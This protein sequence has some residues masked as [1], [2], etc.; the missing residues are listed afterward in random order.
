MSI[1]KLVLDCLSQTRKGGIESGS[2]SLSEQARPR[3]RHPPGARNRLE[4]RSAPAPSVEGPADG[5]APLSVESGS[6]Q[7]SLVHPM[8]DRTTRRVAALNLALITASCTSLEPD[9]PI[10]TPRSEEEEQEQEVGEEEEQVFVDKINDEAEPPSFWLT[11]EPAGEGGELLVTVGR[12]EDGPEGPVEVSVALS[13][14]DGSEHHAVAALGSVELNPGEIAELAGTIA[15]LGFD[16]DQQVFSGKVD[17]VGRV[18]TDGDEPTVAAA[19]SEEL[20]FHRIT[21]VEVAVYDSDAFKIHAGDFAGVV[22]QEQKQ[23]GLPDRYVAQP[24][25]QDPELEELH[26]VLPDGEM[27]PRAGN[28][29]LCVSWFVTAMDSSVMFRP[30]PTMALSLEEDW[31]P[32]TGVAGTGTSG[33]YWLGR[34]GRVRICRDDA[35]VATCLSSGPIVN[36]NSSGCYSWYETQN[37]NDY[38]VRV[39]TSAEDTNG[40]R[41]RFGALSP[42]T[43]TNTSCTDSIGVARMVQT[44]ATIPNGG[45]DHV[46]VTYSNQGEWNIFAYAASAL[47][48]VSSGLSNTQINICQNPSTSGSSMPYKVDFANNRACLTILSGNHS[49]QKYVVTHELGHAAGYLYAGDDMD[50]AGNDE[51]AEYEKDG[52][53]NDPLGMC[54][55]TPKQSSTTYPANGVTDFLDNATARAGDPGECYEPC[56]AYRINTLEWNA[57]ALREAWADTYATRVMNDYDRRAIFTWTNEPNTSALTRFSL[58]DADDGLAPGGLMGNTC[59]EGGA[60]QSCKDD[61]GTRRDWLGGLWNFYA[62]YWDEKC[63]PGNPGAGQITWQ[64]MFQTW[65]V[66]LGSLENSADK[67]EGWNA[68]EGAVYAG[69]GNW[70]P[71]CALWT[72]FDQG[73]EY[74]LHH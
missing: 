1:V 24:D 43:K 59:C 27:V 11:L 17:A 68:F 50:G 9:D 53:T 41:W 26:E 56:S 31:G 16:L 64:A 63:A 62:S 30:D 47:Y 23:S 13:G 48:R 18:W 60:P 15:A 28:K 49:Q 51:D 67:T 3:P 7:L 73:A 69:S 42:C 35:S 52:R 8:N 74:G 65:A 19:A 71:G 20:F 2:Y 66:A 29:T 58:D 21:D 44:E 10:W 38:Q 14:D 22:D 57:L 46:Y 70:L 36:L 45:S 34:N 39:Y 6:M 72:W 4:L 33:K 25:A 5:V 55:G 40:N 32:T 61:A 37:E 54:S 12:E